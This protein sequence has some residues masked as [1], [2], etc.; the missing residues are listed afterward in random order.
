[1]RC[2]GSHRS[3]HGGRK[4]PARLPIRQMSKTQSAPRSA[5][6]PATP[7]FRPDGTRLT[8]CQ[9]SALSHWVGLSIILPIPHWTSWECQSAELCKIAPQNGLKDTASECLSY[10]YTSASPRSTE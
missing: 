8:F 1:M 5:F 6:E 7:V 10:H 4:I 9:I 3:P 2:G